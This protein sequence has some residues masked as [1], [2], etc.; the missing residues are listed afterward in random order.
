MLTDR[1]RAKKIRWLSLSIGVGLSLI[2]LGCSREPPPPQLTPTPQPSVPQAPDEQTPEEAKAAARQVVGDYLE[3]LYAQ[4]YE[5]AYDYLSESSREAHSRDEFTSAA[6][7][8][9]VIYDLE[10]TEVKQLED[11]TAEV[12]VALQEEEE[13]GSKSFEVKRESGRWKIVYIK[14]SPFFPYAE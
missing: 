14:G 2:L 12:I 8:G 6:Q 13:P 1:S 4:E 5:K 7:E 9:Q 10:T 11:D 3:A